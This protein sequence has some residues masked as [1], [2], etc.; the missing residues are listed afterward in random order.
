MV[1]IFQHKIVL[2]P[3][4]VFCFR[5]ISSVAD[6]EGIMHRIVNPQEKKLSSKISEKAGTEQEIAQPPAP[7][8]KTT[9][10]KPGAEN[11]FTRRT[12]L[13][14]SSTEKW[15]R[16]TRK[17]EANGIKAS[18]A[19][20]VVPSPSKE[21]RE[22]LVVTATPFYPD[23]L[24]IGE[25]WNRLPSQMM[26]Q[27]CLGKNLLSEKLADGG[28][29]VGMFG[30]I[31]KLENETRRSLYLEIRSRRWEKLL[32]NESSGKG[33]TPADVTDD[34]LRSKLNRM[35]GYAERTLSS[36]ET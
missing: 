6:K 27:P 8:A 31:M 12:P 2:R 17:K 14:T 1:I 28:T 7:R 34:K 33:G 18:Q 4:S 16:I 24:F 21:N 11:S 29:D 26:S 15:T 32:M 9:S 23:D 3:G 19:A 13:S 35:R 30:D 22:K 5:T 20:F 10:C 36:R 25:E